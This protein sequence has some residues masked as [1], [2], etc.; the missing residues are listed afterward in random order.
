MMDYGSQPASLGLV[1][2]T[3]DIEYYISVGVLGA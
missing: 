1:V 3:D 2:G